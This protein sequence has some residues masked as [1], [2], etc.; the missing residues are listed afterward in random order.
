[1]FLC[2]GT[3][4]PPRA[5]A[6]SHQASH[7]NEKDENARCDAC[8][9]M[10][11]S[12]FSDYRSSRLDEANTVHARDNSVAT[13]HSE[14]HHLSSGC[15]PLSSERRPWWRDSLS[16]LQMMRG[17]SLPVPSIKRHNHPSHTSLSPTRVT[18]QASNEYTC[19]QIVML[20]RS[21]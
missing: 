4:I 17:P 11:C 18:L 8:R 13:S 12:A 2:I 3:G 9:P 15:D 10:G 7:H 16:F 14:L 6:L 21:Q 20:L 5:A 19:L 1:M